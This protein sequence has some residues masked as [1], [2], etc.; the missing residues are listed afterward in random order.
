M[1]ALGQVEEQGHIQRLPLE[2]FIVKKVDAWFNE[3]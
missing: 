1:R 2:R 3:I